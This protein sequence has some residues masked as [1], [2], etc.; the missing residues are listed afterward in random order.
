MPTNAAFLHKHTSGRPISSL[1]DRVNAGS[2]AYHFT[3]E[4]PAARAA[5]LAFVF[6]AAKKS[7]DIHLPFFTRLWVQLIV[8]GKLKLIN[9]FISSNAQIINS[10]LLKNQANLNK[11]AN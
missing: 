9:I 6:F 1:T 2:G 5:I 10:T 3:G 11:A 4:R 8:T 7:H